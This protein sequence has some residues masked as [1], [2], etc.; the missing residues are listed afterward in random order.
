M[1]EV[2]G[3]SSDRARERLPHVG[4]AHAVFSLPRADARNRG[5][6]VRGSTGRPP[7]IVPA[8]A[9]ALI[10]GRGA[11]RA[12][13]CGRKRHGPPILRVVQAENP[14]DDRAR[15]VPSSR[16]MPPVYFFSLLGLSI[17]AHFFV[18]QPEVLRNVYVG[19]AL[20]VGGIALATWARLLFSRAG[21]TIKPYERTER[22]V[23]Q[24]PY[25]F[26]RNPMYVGM[27]LVLF[28]TA[29]CAGTPVSYAAPAILAP[30]LIFG[31]IRHEERAL[32]HVL[33]EDYRRYCERVR[34]WI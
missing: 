10:A 30:I 25:R 34:R 23:V 20:I 1:R 7:R 32:G 11:G 6:A 24:G 31:F 5:A 14:D 19:A 9:R 15:P 2:A 8:G 3:F 13:R 27:M 29:L 28:G 21:T 22:L 4:P 17:A 12:R 26:T 33:G 18:E 16:W